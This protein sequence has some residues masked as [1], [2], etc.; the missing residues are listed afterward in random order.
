MGA[1]RARQ[2]SVARAHHERGCRDGEQAEPNPFVG[3]RDQSRRCGD[4][5]TAV[6]TVGERAL[7]AI[8]DGRYVDVYDARWAGSG[9]RLS[10]I[11]GTTGDGQFDALLGAGWRYRGRWAADTFPHSVDCLDTEAVYV[12]SVRGVTVYLPVWLGFSPPA[13]RATDGVLVRV[14]TPGAERRLR[15]TVQFL[16]GVLHEAIRHDVLGPERARDVLSLA[17]YTH[18]TPAHIHTPGTLLEVR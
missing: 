9:H 16:K 18:C 3:A 7:A 2:A 15:R 11:L 14:D 12:L 17:V 6:S 5:Q 4:S 13:G 10:R 1:G 8:R